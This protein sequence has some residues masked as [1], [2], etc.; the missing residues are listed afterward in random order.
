[1]EW[2]VEPLIAA[3]AI[4]DG[5]R[6]DNDGAGRASDLDRLARRSARGDDVLDDEDALPGREREA[7][8]QRETA[9]LPFCEDGPHPERAPHLLPD[10]DSAESRR[11]D[12][13]HAQIADA[14]REE[15]A[16]AL[17]FGRVLEHEGALQVA[18]AVQAGGQTEVPVEERAYAAE[19]VEHGIGGGNSH[20][21]VTGA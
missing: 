4:D 3:A 15:R 17:G 19:Q 5:R 6:A 8:A 11:E 14:V 10:D 7:A 9:V 13:L 2:N 21:H 16:A 12:C 20:W 18:G 1:M